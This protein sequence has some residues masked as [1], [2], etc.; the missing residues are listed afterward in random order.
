MRIRVLLTVVWALCLL[1]LALRFIRIDY[2][3]FTLPFAVMTILSAILSTVAAIANSD[4]MS[5]GALRV[6]GLLAVPWIF[7]QQWKGGDDG[8][9]LAWF[10]F[11]GIGCAIAAVLG[12]VRVD[13]AVPVTCVQC[14]AITPRGRFAAW[15]VLVSICF[16]PLGL[17]SLFLRRKATTCRNCGHCWQT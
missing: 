14:G 10:F 6:H 15:Q 16:F 8:P 5:R 7:G 9:G 17:L 1:A 4:R 12:F 3:W 13:I 2:R 11:V